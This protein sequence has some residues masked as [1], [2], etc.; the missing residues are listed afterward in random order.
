MSSSNPSKTALPVSMLSAIVSSGPT[1]TLTSG[2]LPPPLL[3]TQLLIRTIFASS[4][5]KDWKRPT[6][7]NAVPANQGD[8]VA[9]IVVATGA[10][11]TDFKI[12][13]RVAGLHHPGTEWGTYAEYCVIWA[14]AAF[15][16][17]QDFDLAEASTFPMAA[18]TAAVGLYHTL[19]LPLPGLEASTPAR[20]LIIYGA[21][22]AVGAF[23]VKLAVLSGVH[24]IIAIAGKGGDYV[25]GLLNEECGDVLLDY[26]AGDEE[27]LR[28]VAEAVEKSGGTGMDL[29]FDAVPDAR[30]QRLLGK[31][32]VALSGTGDVEKHIASVLPLTPVDDKVKRT[33]V[34]SPIIFQ[35]PEGNAFGKKVKGFFAAAVQAGTLRGHPHE[36][37]PGVL[38]GIQL[39]LENLKAG[40]NSAK[41][42]VYQVGEL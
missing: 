13:D 14:H 19:E 40:K 18:M 9:G 15:L 10:D 4:N 2:P 3:P 23:A 16:L 5:P 42:Y 39:G 22:S 38:E 17:P 7:M 12:G 37:I 34:M 25:R 36:V 11:F 20:P 35:S 41:K 29:A 26:R 31:M 30:S 24:P 33:F 8:D 32:L 21:S 1:V 27:L 6:L 28:S